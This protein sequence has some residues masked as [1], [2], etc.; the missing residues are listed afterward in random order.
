MVK[1]KY[2]SEVYRGY[3]IQFRGDDAKQFG[4]TALVFAWAL[5]F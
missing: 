1:K 4:K 3:L 5:K 2:K